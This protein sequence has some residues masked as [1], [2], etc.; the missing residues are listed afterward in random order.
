MSECGHCGDPDPNA[1]VSPECRVCGCDG[2][3]YPNMQTACSVGVNVVFDSR[4]AGCGEPNTEGGAGAS[5]IGPREYI[6]C[7]H[8]GHCLS[9]NFCCAM[10]GRCYAE[11]DRDICAPGPEGTRIAC[12][13]LENCGDGEYCQGEGCDG[14]GGCVRYGH[15]DECGV[16]FEPVCGCDGTTYTSVACAASRGVRVDHEGECSDGGGGE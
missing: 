13:T 1:P 5:T 14:P 4:G 15:E 16:T 8:D 6:V 11:T 12:R 3:T 2:N 7:G 9:G 10:V